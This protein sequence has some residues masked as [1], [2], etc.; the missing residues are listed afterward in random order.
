MA[1]VQIP[2]P[3][4]SAD[5]TIAQIATGSL[6]SGSSLSLTSLTA[7]DTL[8]LRI[9]SLTTGSD[10]PHAFT[11]NSDTSSVYDVGIWNPNMVN[12]TS[13]DGT[14][15]QRRGA[16]STSSQFNLTNLDKMGTNAVNWWDITLTNC[17]ATGFT[18][19]EMQGYYTSFYGSTWKAF[20]ISRGIF[21]SAA[22]VSSIQITSN[23]AFTA[24]NYVLWGG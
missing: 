3:V 10:T 19:Y 13:F 21:K 11:I 15:M 12:T 14:E 1:L 23:F 6:T 9:D 16:S 22:A 24:G 20:P 2:T 18:F 7:Y 8:K 5:K 17:K 4:V